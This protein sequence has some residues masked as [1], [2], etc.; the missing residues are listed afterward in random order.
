MKPTVVAMAPEVEGDG[1]G[2][3]YLLCGGLV[4]DVLLLSSVFKLARWTEYKQGFR[5]FRLLRWDRR[6]SRYVLILVPIL[7]G[8]TALLLFVP[9]LGITR[10]AS[11]S[12]LVLFGAFT[13]LLST[14]DRTAI[15][16][17]GCWGKTLVSVPRA[18]YIARSGVLLVLAATVFGGTSF[19]LSPYSAA[20]TRR[21]EL[22]AL[23]LPVALLLLDSPRIAQ[24][25][26][27]QRAAQGVR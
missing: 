8:T 11:F 9:S 24:I 23:T 18:F 20:V 6:S 1:G 13:G 16:N 12:A 4:A 14:D 5:D 21:L 25:L 2:M 10:L 19:L 27:V 17:C 7:E 22:S 26:V 3:V 15:A